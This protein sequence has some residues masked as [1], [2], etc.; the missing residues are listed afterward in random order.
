MLFISSVPFTA[1]NSERSTKIKKRL[2]KKLQLF[3]TIALATLLVRA[4]H[5]DVIMDW[6][7]KGNEI[8]A[9]K[10]F[11]L[12]TRVMPMLHVAMF[13]AVNAIERRYVPYNTGS[14]TA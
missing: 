9:E 14:I 7:A 8:A 3:C 5:A 10:Q 12:Q 13:E 4:A 11:L 6:N 1:L 2:A